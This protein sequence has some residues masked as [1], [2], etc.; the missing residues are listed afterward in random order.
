MQTA[1]GKDTLFVLLPSADVSG[2]GLQEAGPIV[3][4]DAN[5]DALCTQI[6]AWCVNFD[7]IWWAPGSQDRKQ[8]RKLLGGR[9][10]EW[11]RRAR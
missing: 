8:I 5:T 10:V 2:L 7:G 9:L 11:L 4:C 1:A 3:V 6:G